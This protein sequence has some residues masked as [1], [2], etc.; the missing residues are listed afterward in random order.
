MSINRLPPIIIFSSLDY[1]FFV[2]LSSR[3]ESLFWFFCFY[4]SISASF[5]L[6]PTWRG[7]LLSFLLWKKQTKWVVIETESH[8]KMKKHISAMLFGKEEPENFKWQPE[9]WRKTSRALMSSLSQNVQC[10]PRKKASTFEKKW[11]QMRTKKQKEKDKKWNRE[12]LTNLIALLL[13]SFSFFL[14]TSFQIRLYKV[15]HR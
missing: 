1:C 8:F 5:S 2:F 15:L 3:D 7:V 13:S 10:L 6:L 12:S 14:T 11:V 9:E 4:W